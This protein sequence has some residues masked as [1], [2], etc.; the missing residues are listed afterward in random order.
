MVLHCRYVETAHYRLYEEVMDIQNEKETHPHKAVKEAHRAEH[1]A[2][3]RVEY[4]SHSYSHRDAHPLAGRF[5]GAEHDPNYQPQ[6]CAHEKSLENS[7][8]RILHVH[9][10]YRHQKQRKC[11][12]DAGPYDYRCCGRAD[13]GDE[14]E[15][16][17]NPYEDRYELVGIYVDYVIEFHIIS[18]TGEYFHKDLS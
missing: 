18:R 8:H 11:K 12:T 5:D 17:H 10:D 1:F 2:E 6:C 9:V 14:C 3:L 7:P 4:R 15:H 13:K 16:D